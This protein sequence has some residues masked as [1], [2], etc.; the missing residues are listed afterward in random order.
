MGQTVNL[1]SYDFAGSN[2]A[3]PTL[4]GRNSIGRVS[5]FQAECCRFEPGRPL[6]ASRYSSGVEHFHGKEGVLGSNPSSGSLLISYLE[7]LNSNQVRHH[8]KRSI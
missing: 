1:L 3:L 2:P 4:C 8:G 6:N 5:A 7:T